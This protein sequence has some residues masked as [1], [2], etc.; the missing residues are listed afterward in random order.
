M[1]HAELKSFLEEKTAMYQYPGFLTSDPI[2]VPHGFSRKEDIE[3]SG[4]LTAT[5]AWG[6][7]L[8]IIRSA[9]TMMDLMDW[10]PHAFIIYF[11]EV[12]RV[13]ERQLSFYVTKCPYMQKHPSTAFR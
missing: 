2:Q 13:W 9:N 10:S 1:K 7:R 4:F 5:I 11:Q 3:I 12:R 6:N 8:S